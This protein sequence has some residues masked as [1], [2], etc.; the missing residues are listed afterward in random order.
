MR[1]QD[2]RASAKPFRGVAFNL[3]SLGYA[4]SQGFKTI[5]APFEL[6]PR[7]FAVLR[8]VGAQEGQS[9]Q[10]LGDALQIPRSRM[11]SVVD[12][13]ETRG[14]LE[15]RPNPA[16]RRVRELYLTEAGR[17]LVEQAFGEAVAYE[18]LVTA[19]LT[20]ADREHLLDLLERI[21]T[22]L[23]IGHGAHPA[24]REPR[25]DEGSTVD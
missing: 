6:H 4:V 14:L 17:R 23:G 19:P 25:G 20:V 10:A 12:E 13:L 18:Q 11:V 8:A 1:K 24:L 3:S 7:E 15:R 22:H 2:R 9:Q 5:L 16:D 21:A